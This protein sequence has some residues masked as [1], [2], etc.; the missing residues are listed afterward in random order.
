[1]TFYGYQ[2][3][4]GTGDEAAKVRSNIGISDAQLPPKTRNWFDSDN[5]DALDLATEE[6]RNAYAKKWALTNTRLVYRFEEALCP[7]VYDLGSD[8]DGDI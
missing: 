8:G 1:M 3:C 7:E 6:G 2:L 4:R 5:I